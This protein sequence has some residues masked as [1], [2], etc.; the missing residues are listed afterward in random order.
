MTRPRIKDRLLLWLAV[1]ALAAVL[2]GLAV[3]QYRWS[4]QVSEA[5]GAQM[6]SN[7]HIS[8]MGFRQDFAR[9]LGSAAMEIRSVVS[10]SSAVKPVELKEQFHHWQQTTSHPNLVSY[11]Y[12]WQDPLHEQPLRFDPARDQFEKVE[13][14]AE[15][16]QMKARLL[17]IS[18][19]PRSP[20][21]PSDR[22]NMRRGGHRHA[23]RGSPPDAGVDRRRNGFGRGPGGRGRNDAMIPWA[24]D[25]EIPAL[26]YPVRGLGP[27]GGQTSRPEAA[28]LIIQLNRAVL[29]K[30]IFPELAQKYFRGASGMEYHVT[31]RVVGRNDAGAV[32][33]SS[34]PG[35]R[36][37]NSPTVDAALNLIGP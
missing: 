19:I 21:M 26:S 23:D 35:A 14:P 34:D 30:E 13:W 3:L 10:G 6:Q 28:W 33:Y 27:S 31:V 7:L 15:F 36:E 2:A 8:L 18:S 20:S 17:E 12:L 25:Q 24:V 22:Q 4:A 1:P 29:T 32:L 11:I 37:D 5:A 16:D 9:E